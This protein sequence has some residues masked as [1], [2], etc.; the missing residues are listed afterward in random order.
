MKSS[1]KLSSKILYLL[2][3]ASLIIS[4]IVEYITPEYDLECRII[5]NYLFIMFELFVGTGYLYDFIKDTRYQKKTSVQLLPVYIF[6]DLLLI[7]ALFFSQ[8]GDRHNSILIC[9]EIAFLVIGTCFWIRQLYL[10]KKDNPG[11]RISDWFTNNKGILLVLAIALAIGIDNYRIM[12]IWD[13]N[14]YLRSYFNALPSW[15][16]SFGEIMS[17]KYA[18]HFSQAI[19]PF[20][21]FS[22]WI[23]GNNG[24]YVFRTVMVV[25]QLLAAVAVYS[26]VGKLCTENRITQ[27]IVSIAIIVYPTCLPMQM[28]SP[29]D[30]SFLFLVFMISGY[31]NR[32][33]VIAFGSALLF[34]FS[35]E[36]SI[37]IYFGLCIGLLIEKNIVCRKLYAEK[38][39]KLKDVLLIAL[40][41]FSWL[42]LYICPSVIRRMIT[43]TT[44]ADTS[45]VETMSENT[46]FLERLVDKIIGLGWKATSN[47]NTFALNRDFAIRMFKQ[48]IGLNFMWLLIGIAFL[49]LLVAVILR[50]HSL[51]ELLADLWP[52]AFGVLFG[53]S[54]LCVYITYE[55]TRY[56]YTVNYLLL[57]I[58]FALICRCI[59]VAGRVKTVSVVSGV[60]A[61][62][63]LIESY[64]MFD[65][66]TF[67]VA[68]RY[69]T[70]K[71][72]FV[73][74]EENKLYISDAIVNNHQGL[75]YTL[76]MQRILNECGYTENDL[77]VFPMLSVGD[78]KYSHYG[79]YGYYTKCNYYNEETKKLYLFEDNGKQG[80]P[81]NRVELFPNGTFGYIDAP[82]DL[83]REYDRVFVID[84]YSYSDVFN[85]GETLKNN[86]DIINQFPVFYRSWKCDVYEISCESMLAGQ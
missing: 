20:V 39:L 51:C 35:K 2:G 27:T 72:H 38:K 42:A 37:V 56:H 17:V 7:A 26:T 44:Q 36:P 34:L 43:G 5:S 85:V 75:E 77:M 16:F 53:V 19:I 28:I 22:R 64:Y 80:K 33:R 23:G 40:P 58:C 30:F 52:L 32:Y 69:N 31:V 70:G 1:I 60:L 24:Y 71:G 79:I 29:D 59:A 41:A 86:Y 81:I 63:F 6:F 9:S 10:S 11:R 49:C 65:P 8:N 62:M 83:K 47:T 67:R 57:L 84:Y 25:L 15:D 46:S 73:S 55:W 4:A 13:N 3:A 74:V 18:G 78:S 61:V 14:I 82:A 45:I 76:F 68:R 50:P 48:T 12:P 54:F 21:M 66:I